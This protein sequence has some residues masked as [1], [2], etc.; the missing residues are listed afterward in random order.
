[1]LL[2]RI[3]DENLA[4]AT[5]LIGCQRTGE[6]ILIDPERDIDRYLSIAT[7]EGLRIT[8][9]TETHI[10][11]DF[12]SGT[13]EVAEQTGA[14]VY[15]S[16]EG[17]PDWSYQWL[18]K[19]ASGGSYKH[20]L[21]KDGAIFNVG[22][23]EFKVL[24]TPG[25]TPEH[26][27]F[28]VTDKGS[29]ATEPIGIA[30]GDFLFVGDLGRPDLL[31]TAAG[32]VGSADESAHV[33]YKSVQKLRSL[34]DFVQVWPAHG[35]GSACGK[36]LGA[37]PVSTI[38]YENRFNPA[39]KSATNER[40]FVDYI[41][42]GQ[43]EPPLYFARMKR[44]NKI[45][46]RIL[47]A[48]PEP[49]ALTLSDLKGINTKTDVL[50]D[51][52]D[53]SQ[54]RAGHI[55]GS[56][57]HPFNR[58]FVTDIGSMVGDDPKIYLICTKSELE[59]ISRNLVRIG[60]DQILGWIEPSAVSEFAQQGGPLIKIQ[61][62]SAADLRKKIDAGSVHV[63]DVRGLSEYQEGHIKGAQHIAHT[64]LA[65][66][67][68]DVPTEKSLAVHCRSGVRASYACALLTR[69]GFDVINLRGGILE[70]EK[71]GCPTEKQ[72]EG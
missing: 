51:T 49:R 41:L 5:Y 23:I 56:F 53:W 20:E 16:D 46:P 4:A 45:G 34:P 35:A 50:I 24:H 3:Y 67:L 57:F 65:G 21:L 60:L 48:L 12:L 14:T 40:G 58:S 22:N 69:A 54:F 30:S 44:E 7:R 25:H 17:G 29:G 27:S 15:V 32:R 61:E 11:A 26:I 68:K 8:A 18:D 19:K 13:R 66:K 59:E 6:S 10:H 43:P 70:W 38:G 71:T 72:K 28:L 39:I 36:S 62:E 63:L 52:R 33:L 1:M 64:R 9:V 55:A 31:E 2:R 42:A 47:G 37:V